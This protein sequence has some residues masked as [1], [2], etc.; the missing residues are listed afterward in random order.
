ML[1]NLIFS[2]SVGLVLIILTTVIVAYGKGYRIDLQKKSV[3][4]TGLLVAT[5][6]PNGAQIFGNG[7][8]ISATNSTVSLPPGWY[9]LKIIKEGYL[10]WDKRVK[11]QGEIVTK[12]DALLFP[13][14]PEL[15]PLTQRGIESPKVS[16]DGS[17]LAFIIPLDKTA[18]AGAEIK[19]KTGVW[20][21]DLKDGNVLFARDPRQIAT[22]NYP[23]DF[24][25]SLLYW[26]PDTKQVLVVKKS[27]DEKTKKT[28][29]ISSYLLDTD[30]LNSF[31][32]LVSNPEE[33]MTSW[34]EDFA[35]KQSD[36]LKPFPETVKY[37][38]TASA[39]KVNL[40]PDELKLLYVATNSGTLPQVII[41]PMIGTNSTPETRNLKPGGIYVYDLKEDKNYLLGMQKELDE[42]EIEDLYNP[43]T[44]IGW[45]TDS[46]HLYWVRKDGIFISEFDGMNKTPVYTGSFENNFV[47]PWPS[48]NRLIILTNYNKSAG[49][50]PNLYSINL[51]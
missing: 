14:S 44:R 37:I 31:P 29:L 19:N 20:V 34:K 22:S 50:L 39:K 47:Y 40:S 13:T 1:K 5:S 51:R 6:Y 23:Y 11:I 21:L 25:Q 2:L 41:P 43:T 9:D 28:I 48:G 49:Q 45:Y 10:P 30:K 32:T 36:I 18:T 17:R 12:A 24:T 46:N 3:G 35:L 33:I 27:K 42:G 26:S 4:P 16:P 38:A 7:K 8:L 15:K